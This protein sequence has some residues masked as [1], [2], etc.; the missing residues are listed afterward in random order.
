MIQR[1][2][3]SIRHNSERHLW[4]IQLNEITKANDRNSREESTKNGSKMLDELTERQE[5]KK[6][7][8]G[9]TV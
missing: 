6:M 9:F 7:R 5:M 2:I 8:V 3:E 1:I 4:E